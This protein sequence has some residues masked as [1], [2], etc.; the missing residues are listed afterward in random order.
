MPRSRAATLRSLEPWPIARSKRRPRDQRSSAA[1]RSASPTAFAATRAPRWRPMTSQS[2]PN[3]SQSATVWAKSRAVMRTSAPSSR[4][5]SMSGRSTRTC[6][7]LV[8]S[9]QIRIRWGWQA[10]GIAPPDV[11]VS[12]LQNDYGQ[13]ARPAEAIAHALVDRGLARRVAYLEPFVP[14]P[15]AEPELGR[16]PV[17]GVDV[18]RGTG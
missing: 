7:L 2:I 10:R 3:R 13:L 15:V 8:R 12:W 14:A 17:R 11:I 6:G 16:T 5:A 4:S 18:Y 1:E 9:T